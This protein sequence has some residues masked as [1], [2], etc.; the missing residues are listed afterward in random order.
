[1][2]GMHGHEPRQYET[3]PCYP[4]IGGSVT[5]GWAAAVGRWPKGPAVLAVDG[6]VVLDWAA[7][8]RGLT[9]AFTDLDIPVEQVDMRQEVAP[10]VDIVKRTASEGL[11]DDPDFDKLGQGCL[12]DVFDSIP[13][14]EAPPDGVLLVVGP[15]SALVAHD[16]LWYADLPKRYAEAAVTS[17]TGRNLGQRPGD[18]A[19]T[20]KRLFY[21]DWPLI[22][23]HRDAIGRQIDRCLDMQDAEQPAS[24][25]G[26]TLRRTLA[27]LVTQPF[28]TRPTFNTT[29]WGGHWAQRELGINREDP[30]TALG[31]ELIAPE[32][33]VLI[34]EPGSSVEVPFQLIVAHHPV[35]VLGEAVHARFGNSFPIRFDYLDTMG[36]GN[37]SVHC[38]PQPDYMR[39][40]FGWPYAQH[41]SYYV[42]VG[43]DDRNIYLGLRDGVDL[44]AFHEKASR[45]ER[46]GVEFD[47]E[48]YVQTFPAEPHQLFLVPAGTPHGSGEGN[49]ILEVSA[50]PY[51]YS[52]RLYDWLRR[53]AQ[54][55]QRPVHVEHA[56]R[57]LTTNRRGSQVT[58]DLVLEPVTVREDDGWR[59]E[60]LGGGGELF[61]DVR[62]M[63]L[64]GQTPARD[65][66]AGRFHILN[67]VEGDGVVIETAKGR[68]HHLAYAETIVVP[69]ATGTY[70]MRGTGSGLTRV[71]KALVP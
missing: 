13:D 44:E 34:G 35:D 64:E 9:A 40:V 8:L 53:D 51:L 17:G 26:E 28:R 43:G 63:V 65:N 11:L 69:A 2:T 14:R 45:A 57:N 32:S 37:L 25:D 46:L 62:R 67:V 41:E 60:R 6:P 21:I 15:G 12:A 7:V 71:V 38:H 36:G 48:E 23:R 4:A 68:T 22:D 29:S 19:A 24:I 66:T 31:Y 3:F 10:W 42:M 49:V 61:F 18:G 54:D 55:K 56:F 70:S 52:L 58:G 33:G 27:D 20:T 39:D 5:S 1:M 16:V 50:T 30:N 59:E 47:I